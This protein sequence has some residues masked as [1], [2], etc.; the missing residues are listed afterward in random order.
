MEDNQRNELLVK[1]RVQIEYYL[2][3]E[4]LK[5]DKF[6]HEK[7][8]SDIEVKQSKLGIPRYCIIVKL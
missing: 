1:L 8:S 4:N 3:D 6:F 2:S 7:I 5:G